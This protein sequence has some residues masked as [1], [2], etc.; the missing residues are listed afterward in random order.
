MKSDQM[1]LKKLESAVLKG[2][3]RALAKLLTFVEAD[4]TR[5]LPFLLRLKKRKALRIGVTGPPGA[6]KSTL[7]SSMVEYFRRGNKKVAVLAVDP[8]SP[9]SGGAV[10]GDRVRMSQH[11]SDEGVFIRSLGSRGQ[12]GG[13][14]ASTGAMAR[15]LE[16]AGF[17]IIL[18]ETVGV[19]Q[20]ELDIMNLVD[21]T[22]VV[23]VPESGDVIQTMKA[24]I[25]EIADCFVVNKSDRPGADELA[26]ELEAIGEQ[27]KSP[28]K[29]F[30]TVAV[31]HKGVPELSERLVE[32]C[33]N[34]TPHRRAVQARGE[35]KSL[36]L[37][38][39]HQTIDKKISR[40][41]IADPYRS[42]VE[43]TKNQK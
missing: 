6:G 26:R 21:A 43:I 32:I 14:A 2:D 30:K 10:L 33:R 5:V 19:G 7:V 16:L 12:G 29:V 17:D 38:R 4:F 31:T 40:L 36:L 42:F 24:G 28:R 1:G 11:F 9:F 41:K 39:A 20:T 27:E 34:I 22:A 23:L 18:L 8:S 25:L 3:L 15:V 35:L 13:L 37:W